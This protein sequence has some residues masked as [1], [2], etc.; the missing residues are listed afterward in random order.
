MKRKETEINVVVTFTEGYRQRFTQACLD[1][2][3]KRKQTEQGMWVL[4]QEAE[5]RPVA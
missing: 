2:L 5:A 1:Q 4:K 3:A